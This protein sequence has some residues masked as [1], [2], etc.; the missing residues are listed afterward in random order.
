MRKAR[1]LVL[2]LVALF[3]VGG[4]AVAFNRNYA[5]H[6]DGD[7]EVPVRLTGAQ[8][9][10]IFHL[11]KDGDALE[12]KLIVANIENVFAAHIHCAAPG[13]AGPVGVTLFA[14]TPG[15]GRVSGVLAEGLVVAPD[16]GNA[17]GWTSLDQV[18]AAM[19]GGNTY[20]NVHTNDGVA[21]PNT[22]PGDFPGGEIRG[23]I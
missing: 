18:L 9:Q 19:N 13:V 2:V 4:T 11:S 15:G 12:Y 1:L 20:V 22:G 5:V 10:A 17:C 16:A 7:E 21:P 23:Q 3:A 8:G 6:L 14:G